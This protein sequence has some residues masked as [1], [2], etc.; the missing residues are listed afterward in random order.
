MKILSMNLNCFSRL[1]FFDY[2]KRTKK[3]KA[4]QRDNVNKVI[5]HIKN[6]RKDIDIFLFQEVVGGDIGSDFIKKFEDLDF[7]TFYCSDSLG[8]PYLRNVIA[9]NKNNFLS[10]IVEVENIFSEMYNRWVEIRFSF[11]NEKIY[12]LNYHRKDVND[13]DF[14]CRYMT[15]RRKAF[16]IVM[17]DLNAA[18]KA[19]RADLSKVKKPTLLE[20]ERFLDFFRIFEFTNIGDGKYTY[21]NDKAKRDIKDGR[22]LDHCFISQNVRKTFNCKGYTDEI[23]NA[24]VH[25]DTGF[26]DHSAIILEIN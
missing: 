16:A 7:L 26:T 23:V 22:R 4:I 19:D 8:T 15:R 20:N 10:D 9:V 21:Y 6:E 11:G 25:S 18:S 14:F 24:L 2:Q 12:L 5:E 13:I 1:D 17:G 3:Q